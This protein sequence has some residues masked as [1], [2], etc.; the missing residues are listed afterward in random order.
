VQP[1]SQPRVKAHD[2]NPATLMQQAVAAW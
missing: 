2:G 1:I